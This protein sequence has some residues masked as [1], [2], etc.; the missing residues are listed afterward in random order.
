MFII[1]ITFLIIRRALR[2][3]KQLIYK[4][5]KYNYFLK[6]KNLVISFAYIIYI[7][8]NKAIDYH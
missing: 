4:S 1:R 5:F 7:A 3:L 2:A 8:F 6:N